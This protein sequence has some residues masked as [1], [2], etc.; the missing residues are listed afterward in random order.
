[1]SVIMLN[2]T[3]SA[4]KS[5][6]AAALQDVL[7][8]AGECWLVMSQDDFFSKIPRAFVRYGTMHV[9]PFADQG[10]S[11]AIVD[12]VLLRRVGLVGERLLDAYRAAIVATARAGVNVIVDEVLVDESD[13]QSWCRHLDGLDVHWVGVRAALEVVERRERGRPDRVNGTARAEYDQVHRYASYRTEVDTAVLDPPAAAR[14]IL[15]A[16]RSDGGPSW[17]TEPPSITPPPR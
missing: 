6:L 17:E 8:E 3:S 1:M 5:T 12:G 16:R 15:A 9:G 2:G 4:G 14:A 13:W 10:V 7:T 11:L